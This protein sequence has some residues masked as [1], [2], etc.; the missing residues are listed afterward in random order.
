MIQRTLTD[1]VLEAAAKLPVVTVTGPRQSGK[2][3]LVRAIFP[4]HAYANCGV[5]RHPGIR[6]N[7]PPGVSKVGSENDCRRSAARA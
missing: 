6:H 3:T 7:R 5:S 4:D 1:A 2:T